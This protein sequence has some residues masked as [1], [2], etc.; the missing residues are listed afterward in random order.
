MCDPVCCVGVCCLGAPSLPGYRR[1]PSFFPSFPVELCRCHLGEGET[2]ALPMPQ[3]RW[4]RLGTSP[5][6][7]P[8]LCDSARDPATAM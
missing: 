4:L 1:A 2:L 8:A 3:H 7:R 5:T 6:K